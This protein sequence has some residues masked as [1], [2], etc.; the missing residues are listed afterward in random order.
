MERTC[1]NCG[2]IG[3]I[4]SFPSAGVVKGVQYWRHQCNDCY[5][6]MKKRR[7]HSLRDKFR[8]YKKTL[9]CAHCG[10]QDWRVIQLHHEGDDKDFSVSEGLKRGLSYDRVMEEADKCIPL[11]ANCHQIL[12]HDERDGV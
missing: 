10:I 2:Y 11:C 1:R 8:E 3:L 6:A 4:E 9:K 5:V 7:K 12:H